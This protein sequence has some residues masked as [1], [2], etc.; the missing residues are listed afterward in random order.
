MTI[1]S[2]L[3]ADPVAGFN[4]LCPGLPEL[5]SQLAHLSAVSVRNQ[6]AGFGK[7]SVAD[8]SH[9]IRVTLATCMAPADNNLAKKVRDSWRQAR[10]NLAAHTPDPISPVEVVSALN[11]TK[12]GTAPG[13]DNVHL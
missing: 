5:S 11:R 8:A 10:R 13:Y 12:T 6:A 3:A 9:L 7:R 2:H 4:V 1:I